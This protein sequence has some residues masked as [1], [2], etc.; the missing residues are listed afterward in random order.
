M[1]VSFYGDSTL[2]GAINTSAKWVSPRPA[3]YIEGISGGKIAAVD[4]SM[5]G[6]TVQDAI[7][8]TPGIG[9]EPWAIQIRADASPVVVI[10]YA[11]AGALR[12]G[13]QPDDYA[14]SL[15][16]MVLRA[17]EAGKRVL[18]LGAPYI[19]SPMPGLSDADSAAVIE[20]VDTFDA[21][22]KWVAYKT[23][24]EF[25]DVRAVPFYGLDYMSDGVHPSQAYSQRMGELIAQKI[26]G[27]KNNGT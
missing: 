22:T 4:Y 26:I 25:V 2:S 10:G 5:G 7:A 15:T 11:T 13:G 18:L 3:K 12:F 20:A 1:A 16:A 14:S 23:G 6:A 9:F 21:I 24:A 19:A 17:K 8:G 27:E